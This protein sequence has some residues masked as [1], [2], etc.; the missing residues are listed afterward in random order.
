MIL[1]EN[2]V[3]SIVK[4]CLFDDIQSI[5]SIV[6]AKNSIRF[7]IWEVITNQ[8]AK[9]HEI[10]VVFLVASQLKMDLNSQQSR[11]F[12]VKEIFFSC[13]DGYIAIAFTNATQKQKRNWLICIKI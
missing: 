13:V 10:C 4:C 1:V 8:L 12:C 3:Y 5:L 7:E 9:K 6:Y 2:L 11:K